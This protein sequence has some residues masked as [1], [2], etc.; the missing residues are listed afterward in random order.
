MLIVK[1]FLWL[2]LA[3]ELPI[4]AAA[5]HFPASGVLLIAGLAGYKAMQIIKN[6]I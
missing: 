5:W 3:I 1:I 6:E 2:F 4:A